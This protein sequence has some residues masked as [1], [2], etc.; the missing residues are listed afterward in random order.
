MVFSPQACR[1]P[2]RKRR[3]TL[4]KMKVLRK[5]SNSSTVATPASVKRLFHQPVRI[6]TRKVPLPVTQEE[7]QEIFNT[8]INPTV[9][10]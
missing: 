3:Q 4:R 8:P 2:R 10:L 6:I 7:I 5:G 9:P 1:S